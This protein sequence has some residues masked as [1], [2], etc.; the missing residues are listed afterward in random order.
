M[1]TKSRWMLDNLLR[2]HSITNLSTSSL[3]I[4]GSNILCHIVLV[5]GVLSGSSPE[6]NGKKIGQCL[7]ILRN[8]LNGSL[9][10]PG[11]R[12][13][14]CSSTRLTGTLEDDPVPVQG[15]HPD[16]WPD[17]G[18]VGI[19]HV[20]PPGPWWEGRGELQ[21]VCE[22]A[23]RLSPLLVQFCICQTKVVSININLFHWSKF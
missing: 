15:L 5:V 10:G 13:E 8:K 3:S 20:P 7:F 9:H 22:R 21:T 18:L 16:G 12:G 19:H 6:R 23:L 14:E 17:Q 2:G 4:L 1:W 11:T